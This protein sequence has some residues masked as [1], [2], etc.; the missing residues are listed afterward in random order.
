MV[1]E[2]SETRA[3]DTCVHVAILSKIQAWDRLS[4]KGGATQE[5]SV[6]A[7][8]KPTGFRTQSI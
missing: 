4:G 6:W 8:Q 3:A 5:T 7:P 2:Q 1:L